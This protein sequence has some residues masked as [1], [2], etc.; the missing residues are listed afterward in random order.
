M[1]L[2][3]HQLN[4]KFFNLNLILNSYN[5]FR[6]VTDMLLNELNA[7]VRCQFIPVLD[8]QAHLWTV[9]V[10][11]NE[12][13]HDYFARPPMVLLHGFG[14]GSVM[15][16]KNFEALSEKRVVYS[17]DLL[18]K[19]F[20]RS[21]RIQ[22]SQDSVAAENM[23]IKSIE[24]WRRFMKLKN[25]YLLGHAFG[26]YLAA[27]YVLEYPT[28]VNH[29]LLVDPWGFAEKPDERESSN[30]T[31]MWISSITGFFNSCN[32]LS[33]IRLVGPA[34]PS[35]IRKLRP[36]IGTNGESAFR[37]ISVPFGWAKRPMVKRL[38]LMSRNIPITFIHGSRSWVD[39]KPGIT[40]QKLLSNKTSVR[41]EIVRA[42]GHHVYADQPCAFNE[43][44]Q[45]CVE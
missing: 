31:P 29:L 22:F 23:W 40:I 36:D 6:Y 3:Y 33:L 20:G 5:Y 10:C 30:S 38:P 15:W 45:S 34:A 16:L 39:Q 7:S 9:T 17:L 26:G 2:F 19:G 4:N 43:L 44:V 12:A 42:A 14:S 32:P 8:G 13:D 28:H 1:N 24:D 37:S 25:F 18:G 21:S 27:A 35:L 41:V 11:K